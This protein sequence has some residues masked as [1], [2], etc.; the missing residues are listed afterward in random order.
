[1]ED[2]RLK[3]LQ[4]VEIFNNIES[5]ELR[6]IL[7]CI[8]P[9]FVKYE[10]N[11]M[12]ALAGESFEGMGIVISGEVMVIKENVAGNRTVMA[13][14]NQGHMFGEMSAFS[15]QKTWPASV[16]AVDNCE[17]MFIEISKLIS[18]CEKVCDCH[19]KLIE[20][21]LVLISR[22]ALQ[23]NRKVEY[24]AIKG[25][26]EKIATYLLEQYQKTK[27]TTFDIELNRNELAEFLNVSRPSMS[28]EI[29][30]MKDEGLIDYY[31]STFRIIDLQSLKACVELVN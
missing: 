5:K 26:R 27:K 8:S 13:K 30:R 14:L 22:K 19:R 31:K 2:T 10:K 4:R 29:A 3:V 12:I 9:K 17:V 6:M 25:M 23:L 11:E 21:M 20:N 24:L 15:L 18:Q 1:M 7:N 28:R 16:Q